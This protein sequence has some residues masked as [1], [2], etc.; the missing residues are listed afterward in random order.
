M[1]Q[2]AQH[3][4]GIQHV[5]IP[6]NDLEATVKF[7][8]TLGFSLVHRTKA[9][10]MPVCFL[11]WQSICM[12]VYENKEAVGVNGAIDHLALNVDNIEAAWDAVKATGLEIREPEIQQ[13]PFWD[14]GIRFF[15]IAGPNHEVLE[16]N[17]IL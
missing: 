16:F 10:D 3:V 8:E 14:K 13:L 5:G 1:N 6:T 12:E 2:V 15:T 17:Q 11:K 7:Y 9:G 4:T